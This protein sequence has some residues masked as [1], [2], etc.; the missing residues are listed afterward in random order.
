MFK[1]NITLKELLDFTSDKENLLGGKEFS[2]KDIINMVNESDE[3]MS[4]IFDQN[5]VMVVK[6]ESVEAI[7][8]LGCNSFWCFTY[9]NDNYKQWYQYSYNGVVYVIIDFKVPSDDQEFMHVLIKPL[10]KPSF[11]NK[12]ENESNFNLFNMA[13]ENYFNPYLTLIDLVG[14][15]NLKMFNFNY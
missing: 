4:I 9:G 2:K 14:K 7:K 12:E 15:N 10:Q 3:D 5:N 8:Q 6:V 13:N 1:S 11:Y